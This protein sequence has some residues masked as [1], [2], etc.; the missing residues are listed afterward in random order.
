[1]V[2]GLVTFLQ[3]E[4][5]TLGILGVTPAPQLQKYDGE[6][7]RAIGSFAVLT[8]P[9]AL[10][11]QPARMHI[12]TVPQDMNTVPQDMNL[13]QFN[14][15]FPS[16]IGISQLAVINGVEQNGTLKAGQKAK[17]V[18]GGVGPTNAGTAAGR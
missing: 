2:A 8:D 11:V 6:F 10:N 15:Q 5:K 14:A 18:V 4:G 3:H 12:V 9:V 7:R 17:R 16:T 13:S 1:V